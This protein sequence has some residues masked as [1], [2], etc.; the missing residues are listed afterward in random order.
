VTL[1]GEHVVPVH[2]IAGTADVCSHKE[3][4]MKEQDMDLIA[5]GAGIPTLVRSLCIHYCM[6]GS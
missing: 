4:A 2:V 5:D 1:T 3:H 6:T